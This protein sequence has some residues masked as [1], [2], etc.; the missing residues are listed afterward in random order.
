MRHIA[1]EGRCFLVSAC[2]WLP[3]SQMALGEPI[4]LVDRPHDAP[5]IAGGSMIVSPMGEVLAG[6]LRGTDGQ[7]GEGLIAAQ[8][9]LA[10][11]VRARFDFDAAGHYAR[12]DI[13]RL[14][15]TQPLG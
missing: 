11:I 5:L 7:G 9:D 8:V 3:P 1:H 14:D 2:Q 15:V 4:T 12:P 6:P 10:D 13:F